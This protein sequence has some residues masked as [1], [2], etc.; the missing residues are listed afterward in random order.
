M[1]KEFVCPILS[2]HIGQIVSLCGLVLV[3][4]PNRIGIETAVWVC[5]DCGSR[6]KVRNEVPFGPPSKPNSCDEKGGGCGRKS[7][8]IFDESTSKYIDYKKL[9]IEIGLN[10]KHLDKKDEDKIE[11]ILSQIETQVK[12]GDLIE[13]EVSIRAKQAKKIGHTVVPYG[14]TDSITVKRSHQDEFNIYHHRR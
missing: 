3:V 2:K 12:V 7:G 10:E 11:I 9:I 8:F 6:S 4:N 14:F 13:L 5:E 1:P